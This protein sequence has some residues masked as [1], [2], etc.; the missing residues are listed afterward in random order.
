VQSVLGAYKREE[1]GVPETMR[2][3][4]VKNFPVVVTMDAYGESQH[5]RIDEQSQKVLEDLL[6]KS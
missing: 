6:Q 5:K 1:F 2:V 4:E 3:I